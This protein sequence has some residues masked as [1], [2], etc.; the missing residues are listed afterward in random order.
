MLPAI[1]RYRLHALVFLIGVFLGV[2]AYARVGP[3]AVSLDPGVQAALLLVIS[4]TL[5]ATAG[6]AGAVTGASIA[7]DVARESARSA[8]QEAM[9][10]R[11]DAREAREAD[12]E[13][14]RLA[15]FAD[16][17]RQAAAEFY[18]TGIQVVQVAGRTY[19]AVMVGA[20]PPPYEENMTF[21]GRGQELRLIVRLPATYQAVQKVVRAVADAEEFVLSYKQGGSPPRDPLAKLTEIT[22][23]VTAAFDEFE[24]EMRLE[25]GAPPISQDD[26][27]S[28]Y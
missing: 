28:G 1:R 16:P 23:S 10:N 20:A 21:Y 19:A 24:N 8:Q 11:A 26:K 6:G 17:T 14:T 9:A 27:L 12:R 7:A 5:A 25:L 3:N 22:A 15:R 18:A 13:A 4:V 2:V